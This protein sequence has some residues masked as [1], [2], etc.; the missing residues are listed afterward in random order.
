MTP[1]QILIEL[2]RDYPAPLPRKALEVAG[3]QRDEMVPVFLSLIGE[4]IKYGDDASKE[5]TNSFSFIF[6]LLAEWRETCAYRPLIEFLRLPND[7][8]DLFIGD[9]L[10]ATAW[11]VIYS[12]FDGDFEPIVSLIEDEAAYEFSRSVMFHTLTAI[13]LKTP[14]HRPKV[15][16]ILDAFFEKFGTKGN[17]KENYVWSGWCTTISELGAPEFLGRAKTVYDDG[18]VDMLYGDWAS[19]EKE[20]HEVAAGGAKHDFWLKEY[21][22]PAIASAVEELSSWHCFSKEALNEAVNIKL[23]ESFQK[24]E[25]LFS[26]VGKIGR[27]DPC[28]CGSGK[29]FKKCCLYSHA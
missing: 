21:D 11:R 9:A 10:T 4:A 7:T 22:T 2:S 24:R 27:N 8:L 6:H 5:C 16:S 26:E 17:V 14:I 25:A 12:T 15:I 29:K 1:E 19:Y 18:G 28:P 20:V 3:Q 13:A 23:L